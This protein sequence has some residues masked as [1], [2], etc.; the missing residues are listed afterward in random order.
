M[1]SQSSAQV[2]AY[3]TFFH[4]NG[5]RNSSR[6]FGGG[7][8]KYRK[9]AG[10][11][12]DLCYTGHS[13]SAVFMLNDLMEN[14][15]EEL[16]I[17]EQNKQSIDLFLIYKE[18]AL[19]YTFSHLNSRAQICINI[20]KSLNGNFEFQGNQTHFIHLSNLESEIQLRE[21]NLKRAK[22]S[23]KE[24]EKLMNTYEP[25]AKTPS[26]LAFLI[27]SRSWNYLHRA[28]LF[29]AQKRYPKAE[30]KINEAIKGFEQ[31]KIERR[32][33][34]AKEAKVRILIA[35]GQTQ[36]E[37]LKQAEKLCH[38]IL[39]IKFV[40]QKKHNFYIKG[41]ILHHLAQINLMNENSSDASKFCRKAKS[42]YE[43]SLPQDSEL[44]TNLTSFIQKNF[45]DLYCD[46]LSMNDFQEF[47]LIQNSAMRNINETEASEL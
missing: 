31:V 43:L 33:A 26:T 21:G 27:R 20:A 25:L 42:H 7:L 14:F 36:P 37:K 38:E 15:K 1:Y 30:D 29:L 34:I 3:A 24:A 46:Q 13:K 19:V 11:C 6:C 44:V 12:M 45:Y 39:L 28:L 17:T 10:H 4:P 22:A 8:I 40:R 32:E 35:W 18:A 23:I 2:Q 16:F 41:K 5:E 47:H 9:I